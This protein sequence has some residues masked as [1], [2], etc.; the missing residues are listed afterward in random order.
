M[1]VWTYFKGAGRDSGLDEGSTTVAYLPQKAWFW[2]IPLP[3]DEVSVGVVAGKDYLF[4][5]TTSLPDVFCRE[6]GKNRW[7]EERLAEGRQFG[8]YYATKE[9]SYR[10]AY[11]AEDG[12]V[13]VGDAFS[14]LD[15]VFSSGVYFALRSGE[16]AADAA[17]QALDSDTVSAHHFQDYSRRFRREMEVMRMLVYAFYDPTFSFKAMVQKHPDVSGELTDCL[18]GCL[19]KD[20]TKLS[21]A[22]GEFVSL[23]AP[24][25][26]GGPHSTDGESGI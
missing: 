4:G 26:C 24:M 5:E 2:Y 17:H 11:C 1:A 22:L 15:P 23:P 21:T 13:L 9:A 25:S 6:V 3:S 19:D 7:I 12:L 10:S 16:W 18:V 8:K 20:F 14:F